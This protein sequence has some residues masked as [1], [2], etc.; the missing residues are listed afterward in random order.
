[1]IAPLLAALLALAAPGDVPSAGARGE[2][3]ARPLAGPAIVGKLQA[4]DD[5]GF[6]VAGPDGEKV[7][8]FDQALSVRRRSIL[9]VSA[10]EAPI[11]V[12]LIDGSE[13]HAREFVASGGQAELRLA[14]GVQMQTLVRT[15]ASV[16]FMTDLPPELETRWDEILASERAGDLVVVRKTTKTPDDEGNQREVVSLD[17]F[18][19]VLGDVK[20]DAVSFTFSERTVDVKRDRIAGLAWYQPAGRELPKTL[21]VLETT[22]GNNFALQQAK[23]DGD[24]LTV[25]LVSGAE[26]EMPL[27][28][29]AGFDFSGGKILYLSD[30]KPE[31]TTYVPYFL[32][33]PSGASG[34]AGLHQNEAARFRPR[35]DRS[36]ASPEIRLFGE[37]FS[38]G[39]VA[40]SRSEILYRLPA[41]YRRLQATVGVDDSARN[42]F[43]NVR[44]IVEDDDAVLFDGVFTGQDTEPLRLD[45]DVTGARRLKFTIDYGDKSDAG[46]H[47]A[48]G[49]LRV[50]E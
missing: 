22:A 25:K 10:A 47:L 18:E 26:L 32:T 1:M 11:L 35:T 21:C 31:S 27:A 48:L 13:I 19:G 50:L 14:G 33:D 2:V 6:R 16:R 9:P 38:K 8:S 34:L 3:E 44:L 28:D 5:G 43:S 17:Y 40:R 30:L 24:R 42:R 23:S 49:D 4:I 37:S 46:D 20:P 45:L 36:I 15:I 7:L 12:R 41:R 29:A 39:I